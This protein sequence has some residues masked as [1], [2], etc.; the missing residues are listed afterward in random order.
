VTRR[1]SRRRRRHHR[2]VPGHQRCWLLHGRR[3]C[4][5]TDL[6]HS[7]HQISKRLLLKKATSIIYFGIINKKEEISS[8]CGLKLGPLLS[9]SDSFDKIGKSALARAAK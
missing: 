9:F 5:S 7:G 4:L 6:W 2:C 1:T 8:L 3:R